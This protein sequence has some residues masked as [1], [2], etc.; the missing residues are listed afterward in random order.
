MNL[1]HTAPKE[2]S[3]PGS[4]CLLPLSNLVI[5]AADIKKQALFSRLKFSGGIWVKPMQ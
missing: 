2:Q 3:D 5:Y 1:D 4:L